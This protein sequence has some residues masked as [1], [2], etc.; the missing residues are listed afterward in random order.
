MTPNQR[1]S[2]EYFRSAYFRGWSG[3]RLLRTLNENGVSYRRQTFY[4]DWRTWTGALAE[5]QKTKYYSY[6][7]VLSPEKY[8]VSDLYQRAKYTTI[9]KVRYRDKFTGEVVE[10]EITIAHVHEFQGHL[11]PDL[12]QVYTKRDLAQAAV[13]VLSEH[14]DIEAEDL[15][16]IPIIGFVNPMYGGI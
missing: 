14:S 10:R 11:V 7:K 8:V 5:W 16:V 6:D 15:K 4:R 3:N 9:A 12:D 13:R 1:A 2:Q